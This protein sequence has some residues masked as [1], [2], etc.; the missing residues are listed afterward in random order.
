MRRL[1]AGLA[2]LAFGCID[3]DARLAECDAGRGVCATDAGELAGDGGHEGDGGSRSD[4]GLGGFGDGGLYTGPL[5][6]CVDGGFCWVHPRPFGEALLAVDGTSVDDLWV[7]GRAGLVAHWSGGAWSDH[8]VP[9]LAATAP[10]EVN[11]VVA[12]GEGVWIAGS[13]LGPRRAAADGGWVQEPYVPLA[14]A[15]IVR[16][17]VQLRPGL[18]SLVGVGTRDDGVLLVAVRQ[19]DGSWRERDAGL[20]ADGYAV[21]GG[22]EPM[23][24]VHQGLQNSLVSLAGGFLAGAPATDPYTP[25]IYALWE[26]P[27][28]GVWVAGYSCFLDLFDGGLLHTTQGCPEAFPSFLAGRWMPEVGVNVV[29]GTNSTILEGVNGAFS[30]PAQNAW[31]SGRTPSYRD[32]WVD[33]QGHGLAVSDAVAM[34]WRDPSSGS[35][36]SANPHLGITQDLRRDLF[37]IAAAGDALYVGGQGSLEARVSLSSGALVELGPDVSGRDLGVERLWTDGRGTIITIQSDYDSFGQVCLVAEDGA[38][39]VLAEQPAPLH[40]LWVDSPGDV[41]A[42]GVGG[43]IVRIL[44]GGVSQVLPD[45]GS[46]DL[47]AVVRSQEHVYAGSWDAVRSQAVIYEINPDLS[48]TKV[49]GPVANAGVEAFAAAPT[50]ELWAFGGPDLIVTRSSTGTWK[51]ELPLAVRNSVLSG[52]VAF[53][54]ND[55]WVSGSDGVVLHFDGL[56][57]RYVESGT[58]VSLWRLAGRQVGATREV[59]VS[60]EHGALLVHQYPAP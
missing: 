45:G 59:W 56:R 4:G 41:I 30:A 24:A 51:Q 57:W 29:V 15:G 53:A 33:A 49:F 1:A 2:L 14:P 54:A 16:N 17:F 22:G 58:R 7:T 34:A 28:V 20:R 3:F 19:A 42:V 60:G 5:G 6:F 37:G 18:S 32:V 8:R 26:Q 31:V 46:E 47:Y 43:S 40:G 36:S 38:C 12:T 23:L 39:G 21:V 13:Q 50:G 44:D 27:G 11:T 55:V 9:V 52:A 35:W 25:G 48:M 10:S